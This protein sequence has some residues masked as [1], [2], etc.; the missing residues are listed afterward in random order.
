MTN[1]TDPFLWLY[2]HTLIQL[3]GV[4]FNLAQSGQINDTGSVKQD[5][6]EVLD[7]MPGQ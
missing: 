6:S 7:Q 4:L 3:P 5:Y 2:S 1:P